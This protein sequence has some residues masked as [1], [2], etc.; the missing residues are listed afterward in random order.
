MD[1][2]AHALQRGIH[3]WF[4]PRIDESARLSIGRVSRLRSWV[5]HRSLR[6]RPVGRA[7][8]AAV[9]R[10]AKAGATPARDSLSPGISVERYTPVFQ[11]EIRGAIPRCP[12]T[13][14][15]LKVRRLLREQD[16][17]GAL[18]AALTISATRTP[19]PARTSQAWLRR[20]NSA[21]ASRLGCKHCSDAAVS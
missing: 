19:V 16:Q 4:H 20:F 10:T 1:F 11:T 18:P 13:E 7:A 6:K 14:R 8:Q 5:G 17:A 2:R 15:S 3:D 9:C 12:T 21:F